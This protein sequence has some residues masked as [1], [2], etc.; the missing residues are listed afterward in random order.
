[1]DYNHCIPAD[2]AINRDETPPSY[3]SPGKYTFNFKGAKN[4]TINGI[5]DRRQITAT[6]AISATGEFLPMQLIYFGKTKRCLR[7]FPFPHP[8][9]VNYTEN[10]GSNQR[11][12]IEH[13]EK[14]IFLYLVKIKVQKDYPKE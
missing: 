12:A 14:V 10:Y 13:F 6:F 9:Q 8:F 4:V 11:K 1:M 5:D 7:N 3:V 2:I